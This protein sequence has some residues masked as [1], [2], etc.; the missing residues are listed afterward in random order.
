M[1]SVIIGTLNN[2]RPLVRTLSALVPAAATGVVREVIITDGGSS[3]ATLEVADIAG[4]DVAS[5]EGPLAQRFGAAAG[6]ARSEWLMFLRPGA[7]P[8][9]GWTDEITQFVQR[10][11]MQG[12]NVSAAAFRHSNMFQPNRSA[13][14]EALT[15][16]RSALFSRVGP[17]Q[18]LI[19]AKR[20]YTKIGGHPAAS[21]PEAELMR[22]VGK[23]LVVLRSGAGFAPD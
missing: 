11:D 15:M 23:R 21:D 8:D 7:I 13:L 5:G 20:H 2:E 9:Q 1:L 12:D 16:L 22:N 3:D 17:N 19:I 10:M 6:K 4:C 18:G 14:G